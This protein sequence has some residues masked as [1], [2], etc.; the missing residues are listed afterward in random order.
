MTGR[1]RRGGRVAGRGWRGLGVTGRGWR[2]GGVA[3]AALTS[4]YSSGRGG[5]YFT[6]L[7]HLVMCT[8]FCCC[9]IVVVCFVFRVLSGGICLMIFQVVF[10]VFLNIC[11]V[12][13]KE[14]NMN[15]Q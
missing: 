13:T 2:G 3:G 1:G 9:L 15:S 5:I 7:C 6:E 11:F 8:G 10:G 4:W 12:L 14:Q